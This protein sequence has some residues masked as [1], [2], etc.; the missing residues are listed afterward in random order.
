MAVRALE[1]FKGLESAGDTSVPD[2]FSDKGD[3]AEYA[4]GSMATL[5]N[6]GLIAGS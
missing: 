2:K 4:V 1:K 5:V 3:I 6:E